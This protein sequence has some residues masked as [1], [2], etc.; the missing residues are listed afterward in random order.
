LRST[1]QRT[2]KGPVEFEGVALFTGAMVHAV[3]KPA[4][5]NTGIIFV[6]TDLESNPQ[7]PAHHTARADTPHRTT[8]AVEAAQV[9]TIEHLM[10]AL[11]GFD[12]TNI[13]IELDGPE[14]PN[15]DGSALPFTNAI[16][17]VGVEDQ[18]HPPRALTLPHAVSVSDGDASLI[19]IPESSRLMVTYSLDYPESVIENQTLTFEMDERSF[20][21]NLAGART[22]C[23]ESE[24][25][26]L[27][28]L[29]IQG[30]SYE[31]ALVVGKDGVIQNELRF[32]D[33]FVRHKILD[34][35]GDINLLGAQLHAHIIGIRSGHKLN[36]K[37][38]Q[39]LSDL[40]RTG[41]TQ[42]EVVMDIRRVMKVLWHRYPMLLVDK[43]I[44][45][46]PN[47]RAVG[48]KNVTINEEYFQGHFPE[49]PI[50]P[51]M[52][53]IEAMAQL[54]GILLIETLEATNRAAL[55]L[56]VDKA[57]L[58][59]TVQPGDQLRLEAEAV[60]IKSRTALVKTWAL[61]DGRIVSEAQITFIL[62]DANKA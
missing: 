23:L 4:P 31:N 9:Q 60:A 49:R 21:E 7:I 8:V 20:T 19:A 14:V 16:K 1:S 40:M 10:A 51:G 18:D 59:R 62:V 38:V 41:Q 15:I 33:E 48:I 44:E 58:R 57:K 29:G 36:H 43:V 6:R 42:P 32:P 47:R 45:L 11:N 3:M 35:L 39:R 52:L 50:M 30:G 37:L 2:I 24:I 34:I 61:V 54:A 27:K 46:E 56:S 17:S 26:E 5:V 13:F 55:L 12:I 25:Q 53:Q 22:F 28:N